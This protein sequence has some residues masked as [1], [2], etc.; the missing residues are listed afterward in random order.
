MFKNENSD[1]IEDV[2]NE[3]IINWYSK[4]FYGNTHVLFQIIKIKQFLRL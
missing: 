1:N 3:I 4:P 2:V